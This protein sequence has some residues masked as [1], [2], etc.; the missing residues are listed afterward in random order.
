MICI[1]DVMARLR[2][3]VLDDYGLLAALRWYSQQFK[4]RTGIVMEVIGE[5]LNPRLPLEK[6]TA[7]FRIVQEAL[8]NVAKHAKAS[9]VTLTLESGDGKGR[10]T[11]ADDGIGFDPKTHHQPGREPEWGLINM[12]ERAEAIEGKFDIEIAPGK[13]TKIIVEV[14]RKE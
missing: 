8:N 7:L 14:P 11:I 6:E 10:L 4:E 9:Q 2:P 13:G 3:P 1:R 5:E 12:R